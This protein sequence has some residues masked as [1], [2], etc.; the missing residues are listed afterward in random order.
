MLIVHIHNEI[1]LHIQANDGSQGPLNFRGDISVDVKKDSY[2]MFSG[3]NSMMKM[4]IF[5]AAKIYFNHTVELSTF[6]LLNF[7]PSL[8]VLREKYPFKSSTLR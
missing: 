1:F 7:L 2:V 3:D 8:E 6:F 4:V 5:L